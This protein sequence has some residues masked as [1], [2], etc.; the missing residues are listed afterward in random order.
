MPTD[1]NKGHADK[2]NQP[3][4]GSVSDISSDSVSLNDMATHL[5]SL[6]QKLASQSAID[7][8]NVN[9]IRDAITSGEYRIDPQSVA[10]KLLKVDNNESDD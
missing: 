10:E 1:R 5:K 3:D 4:S 6:E 7:Q 2:D 9:R 8:E